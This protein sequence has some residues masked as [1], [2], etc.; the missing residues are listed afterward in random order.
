[1]GL[2]HTAC[3]FKNFASTF[4]N[5]FYLDNFLYSLGI[6]Y[7]LFLFQRA[8]QI[9]CL[10]CEGLCRKDPSICSGRFLKTQTTTWNLMKIDDVWYICDPN[11]AA[12]HE[13]DESKN[14]WLINN[15]GVFI[16][17]R[18]DRISTTVTHK[19]QYNY[20]LINPEE[21][22]YTN[23]PI[24]PKNQLLASE[25]LYEEFISNARVTRSFFYYLLSFEDTPQYIIKLN[26]CTTEIMIGISKEC[27]V[28]FEYRLYVDLSSVSEEFFEN[29]IQ[30][31]TGSY[32][33][34]L[35][36]KK[37]SKLIIRLKF[38]VKAN[39]KFQLLVKNR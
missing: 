19:R 15:N 26:S 35:Q 34:M 27:P 2:L 18:K 32:A 6:N 33:I 21:F 38:P 25:V 16:L 37:S 23:F 17:S 10:V 1:M 3:F 14:W 20:F 31:N 29:D 11:S 9:D 30:S 8:T 22:I 24:N 39:Y 28:I 36:D 5:I 4:K 13:D 7:I 12:K